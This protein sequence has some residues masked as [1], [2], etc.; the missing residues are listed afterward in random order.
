MYFDKF[1]QIYY[2]FIINGKSELRTVKDIT[3]NVR[4]RKKI[5]SQITLYDEY[6]IKDGETPDIISA[7]IYGSSEY[8]WVIMLANERFNHLEDFP[9]GNYAFELYV[10]DKYGDSLYDTH[11][12]EDS[13]GFVVN[14]F[15]TDSY[16]V[17]NYE[18]ENRVN[19]SKR[20]IKII[21]PATLSL[22]LANY[23]SLI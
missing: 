2:E 20:R 10:Q 4:F 17:S 19:E 16:P 22:I 8:H 14:N 12:Y 11:H 23:K 21:S 3:T 1:K 9:K 18:Y 15:A 5:L 7:K 13:N 6:D